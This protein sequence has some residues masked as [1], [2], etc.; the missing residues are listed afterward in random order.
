[1][2]KHENFRVRVYL[3]TSVLG[4]VNNIQ[5]VQITFVNDQIVMNINCNSKRIFHNRIIGLSPSIKYLRS[6]VD[7]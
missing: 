3:K 7:I 2:E 1:M 5:F 4:E 6:R